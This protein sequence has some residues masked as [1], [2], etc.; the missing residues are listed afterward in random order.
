MTTVKPR[1][2]F[3][4]LAT[5]LPP[6]PFGQA[7]VLGRLL[8]CFSPDEYCLISTTP[9]PPDVHEATFYHLSAGQTIFSPLLRRLPRVNVDKDTPFH[10]VFRP[11]LKAYHTLRGDSRLAAGERLLGALVREL[12]AILER[13]GYDILLACNGGPLETWAAYQSCRARGVAFVPYIFDYFGLRYTGERRAFALSHEGEMLRGA[14]AIIVTNEFMAQVYE[15]QYGMQ[16]TIVR[17]PSHLPDLTKLDAAPPVL[18]PDTINIVYTG[19]IYSAH[20]DAFLNLIAAVERLNR[21]DLA[22]HVYTPQLPITLRNAGLKGDCF[23][24]HERVDYEAVAPLQRQ[25]DVLFLPLAFDSPIPETVNTSSPGKLGEYLAMGRPILVHAPRDSFLSWYFRAHECGLV[26]DESDPAAL[27]EALT[28]LLADADFRAALGA[29]AQER[30][31]EFDLEM[32]G[33]HFRSVLEG[34]RANV[35][36]H[37][38]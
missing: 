7:L 21:A 31:R 32:V 4:V 34:L 37:S 27:A 35:P 12:D 17:N 1:A 8:S 18:P 11:L 23:H 24:V 30:A 22:I 5:D 2:K 3:A 20:Y 26:V 10:R 33:P 28:R 13:E 9:H 29:R 14:A 16:S 25:A 19:A 38:R 6:S 15:Q 36:A